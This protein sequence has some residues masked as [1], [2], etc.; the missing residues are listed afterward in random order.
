MP[1]LKKGHKLG[2]QLQNM[3][4][5]KSEK[6]CKNDFILPSVLRLDEEMKWRVENPASLSEGVEM[7]SRTNYSKLLRPD[8]SSKGVPAAGM[9]Q[10][11]MQN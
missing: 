1:K 7:I 10:A 8:G 9:T 4:K 2:F 11:E 3:P 6:K 5:N